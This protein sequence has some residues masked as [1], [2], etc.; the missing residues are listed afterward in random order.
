MAFDDHG[1]D[2]HFF[3]WRRRLCWLAKSRVDQNGTTN[4]ITHELT[5]SMIGRSKELLIEMVK[6][7]RWTPKP[8]VEYMYYPDTDGAWRAS[9]PVVLN[10]LIPYCSMVVSRKI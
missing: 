4:E 6:E 3:I 10:L 9:H 2:L 1:N 8:D 7:F 5:V